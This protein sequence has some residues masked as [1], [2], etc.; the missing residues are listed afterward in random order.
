MLRA[1]FVA[2]ALIIGAQAQAQTLADGLRS[3]AHPLAADPEQVSSDLEAV[4]DATAHARVVGLG[5][6]THGT[7][8]VFRLKGQ[9]IRKLVEEGRVRHLVFEMSVGEGA[10]LDEFVAG[11]RDDLDEIRR[12][13]PLWM[14]KADAF[15]DLLE[16]LRDYNELTSEPVRI[17]GMEAQ[18]ADRSVRHAL[19]YLADR[20]PHL[21]SELGLEFGPDRV[22]SGTSSAEDFAFLYAPVSDSTFVAYQRLFLKLRATFDTRRDEFVASTGERAFAEA[23]RHV[24]AVGQFTSLAL[25]EDPRAQAQL[26]DYV[27]AV[28]VDAVVDLADDEDRVVVWGH[29]E[30]I[31]KREGNGGYDVLGRQLGRWFGE[32]YYAIGFDYGSGSYRAPGASGWVHAVGSPQSDSFTAALAQAGGHDLF[33]DLRGALQT[34]EGSEALQGV[35]TVRASAGGYVPTRDGEQIYDQ[36]ITLADRYDGLLFVATTTPTVLVG[37]AAAAPTSIPDSARAVIDSVFAL[38]REN[39]LHREGADWARIGADFSTEVDSAST[40]SAALDAFRGVFE[41]LDDVHSAIF[42]SGQRIGYYRGPIPSELRDVPALIRLSAERSGK[43]MGRLLPGGVGYISVPS[44]ASQD[45]ASVNE[46]AQALRD[47]VCDLAPDV[48][49][50]WVVDLRVNEGGNVYPML[51]G[52]GDL[53]GDGVAARSVG[54]DGVAQ[55]DWAIREGVLYLGDHQTATVE[56]R[57]LSTGGPV[58]VLVGPATLSSGQLVAVAFAGWDRARLF[59]DPTA[60]GY[61]TANQWYQVTSELA[62]NLSVSYFADRSGF[63]HRGV[64]L[65][66]EEVPGEWVLDDP[67]A[68]PV[69]QRAVRWMSQD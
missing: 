45:R 13:L 68:D 48:D 58:A 61:A 21:A 38:I 8:E 32:D 24:A 29:N 19:V 59:G 10:D 49:L 35:V 3:F 55:V 25:L 56:R 50:G 30:H 33:L 43:P 34:P 40:V 42:H 65:P 23:R 26:R 14:F 47:V 39:S 63:V 53:L 44:Y 57:C 27:M 9:V 2:L 4:L 22:A 36:T 37:P 54:A 1:L 18:Y 52:L 31:W 41:S 51:S 64:V 5:E 11:R 17:Y 66:D 60:D 7:T 46:A 16:W 20:D 67:E 12:G 69:V 6:P 15:A 62:L 28:N